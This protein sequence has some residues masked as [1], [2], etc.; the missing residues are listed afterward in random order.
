MH[1]LEQW[2]TSGG[3]RVGEW[4]ALA[5]LAGVVGTLFWSGSEPA[6]LRRSRPGCEQNLHQIA[7]A[8]HNYVDNYQ[9][10]PPAHIS[11]SSGRPMHSW[12]VLL[13][14]F[15]DQRELYDRYDFGEPWDGPHNAQLAQEYPTL[16]IFRCPQDTGSGTSYAA[17]VGPHTAWPLDRS[18]SFQDMTDGTAQTLLVVEVYDSGIH[19]MEPRDL[20]AE[21][22]APRINTRGQLGISSGHEGLACVVFVDGHGETLSEALPAETL[23]LLIGRDD[24]QSTHEL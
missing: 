16:E 7:I 8:L 21:Q 22:M 14:P 13:L 15:L 9:C 6:G 1:K 23:Q 19:W 24:G 12:R 5:F 4:L 10:F 17:I 20:D 2:R 3:S 11:D 18:C